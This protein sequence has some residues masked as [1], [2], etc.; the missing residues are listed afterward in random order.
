ME[1]WEFYVLSTSALNEYERSK[2]SITINS[3]KKLTNPIEYNDIKKS[4][5]NTYYM[6]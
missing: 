1:Q 6:L 5:I 3:L 4:I 2:T